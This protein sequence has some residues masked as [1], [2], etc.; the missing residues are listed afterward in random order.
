M[1][2]SFS[3][4]LEIQ[5]KIQVQ[6]HPQNLCGFCAGKNENKMFPSKLQLDTREIRSRPSGAL[7]PSESL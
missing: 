1:R 5:F 2:S 6:I 3:Y 7:Y 4:G